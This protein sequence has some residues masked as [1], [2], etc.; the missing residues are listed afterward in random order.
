MTVTDSYV[1][2][3]EVTYGIS[4]ATMTATGA[5][6]V[7]SLS[8][9]SGTITSLYADDI[10]AVYGVDAATMTATSLLSDSGTLTVGGTGNTNNENMTLDFETT[11]DQVDFASGTGVTTIVDNFQEK[12]I[13]ATSATDGSNPL[14]LFLLLFPLLLIQMGLDY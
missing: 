1:D 3:L 4:T 14:I 11:A 9:S 10:T 6:S 8:T 13:K 5:V 2:N 7:G 12:D